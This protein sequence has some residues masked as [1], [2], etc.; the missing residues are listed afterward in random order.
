ALSILGLQ[1][2]PPARITNGRVLF[3]GRDVIKMTEEELRK[4]RGKDISMIFQDPSTFLNPVMRIGDQ[5]KEAIYVHA[6]TPRSIERKKAIQNRVVEL[7]RLVR[8][9]DPESVMDR[10]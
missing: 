10:Y 4:V 9:P 8:I 6:T 1:P 3:E 7:L 5:I 2:S